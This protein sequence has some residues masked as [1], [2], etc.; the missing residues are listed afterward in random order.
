M[1]NDLKDI[2]TDLLRA[3]GRLKDMLTDAFEVGDEVLLQGLLE[4][5]SRISEAAQ[6]AGRL[7][8]RAEGGRLIKRVENKSTKRSVAPRLYSG[9]TNSGKS[10]SESVST[11]SASATEPNEK[12]PQFQWEGD[13]LVKLGWSENKGKT[14]RHSCQLLDVRWIAQRLIEASRRRLP[15]RIGKALLRKEPLD[16]RLKNHQKYA[17][18]DW[19]KKEGLLR[20][21]EDGNYTLGTQGD[22]IQEIEKRR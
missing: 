22:L 17:C 5:S 11:M 6:C 9:R 2:W 14:Y 1:T 8:V 18:I 10:V 12:Y 3:D 21:E 13:K 16:P 20:K 4:L 19:L 7:R 15:F